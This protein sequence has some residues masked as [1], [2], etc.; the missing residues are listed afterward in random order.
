MP[1]ADPEK[2]REYHREYRRRHPEKRGEKRREYQREY[3]R[4]QREMG[5]GTP[6]P[7]STRDVA[8]R[9]GATVRQLQYW[10]NHGIIPLARGAPQGSGHVRLWS[11]A[12]AVKV[13][14]LVRMLREGI[15][16]QK[17]A[18]LIQAGKTATLVITRI[19][20]DAPDPR[21]PT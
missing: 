20:L 15:T 14:E 9:T 11:A 7:N 17:A 4:R 5:Y 12:D 1:Y 3:Q 2:Q 18:E 8:D 6:T 16:L 21:A 13:A 19:D 10:T